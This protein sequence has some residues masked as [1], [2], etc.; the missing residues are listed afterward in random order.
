MR[1]AVF[2]NSGLPLSIEEIEDPVPSLTDMVIK[3]CACGICGA[4]LHW[5]EINNEESGFRDIHPSAVMGHEFSGKIVEIGKEVKNNWKIGER[6]CAMP[7]IGCAKCSNCKAGR[8]H[9][10]D[11]ALNSATPGNP[12]AYSE[13]VRIGAQE[14]FRLPDSVTFQEGALVEPVAVGFY[15][16]KRAKIT[17]GDDVLIVE[18]GPV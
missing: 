9:L 8:P 5:S 12:G 16:V 15:A 1:A 6:V 18:G 14:T 13:L 7:Q 3:L 4:D 11:K 2:K 17:A 10:C